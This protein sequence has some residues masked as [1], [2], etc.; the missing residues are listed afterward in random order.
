LIWQQTDNEC[1]AKEEVAVYRKRVSLKRLPHSLDKLIDQTIDPLRT[2]LS[3]PDLDKDRRASLASHCSKTITQYKFE[4]MT[5]IIA[6]AEDTA[7]AHAQ[8]VIDAKNELK[9]LDGNQ[10]QSSTEEITKAI[11][12]RQEN[13][14]K[15][16]QQFLE[17][18]LQSFFEQA[19]T[20][21]NDDGSVPVGA[22]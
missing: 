17:H 10:P 13:M 15:R 14:Q 20:E 18:Q 12:A 7:R 21:I 11:E 22:M 9:L 19:P 2:M 3:R 1:K 5:L 4:L 6:T 16:A 8:L